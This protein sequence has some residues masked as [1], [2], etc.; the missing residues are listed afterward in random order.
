MLNSSSSGFVLRR[1]GDG[2]TLYKNIMH[3]ISCC[4][5]Q[6]RASFRPCLRQ[7]SPKGVNLWATGREHQ[8]HHKRRVHPFFFWSRAS[9]PTLLPLRLD[10]SEC[11]RTAVVSHP[12]DQEARGIS[13]VSCSRENISLQQQQDKSSQLRGH[14]AKT[15]VVGNLSPQATSRASGLGLTEGPADPAQKLRHAAQEAVPH[16]RG[17]IEAVVRGRGGSATAVM[18][19]AQRSSGTGGPHR[20]STQTR[21]VTE[22]L[23]QSLSLIGAA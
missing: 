3:C 9:Y 11:V 16:N 7:L 2:G 21:P 8:Q 14:D 5:C 23:S 22:G 4:Y 18:P 10:A 17:R 15:I 19:A 13:K 20:R 1:K 6:W 12:F